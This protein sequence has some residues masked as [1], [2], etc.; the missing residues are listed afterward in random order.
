MFY[1]FICDVFGKNLC[2]FDRLSGAHVQENREEPKSNQLRR[3]EI[4]SLNNVGDD[5]C[6]V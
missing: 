2:R 5:G 1:D 6:E 3:I 4:L